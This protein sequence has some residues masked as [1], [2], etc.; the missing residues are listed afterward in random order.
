[1]GDRGGPSNGSDGNQLKRASRARVTAAVLALAA[2]VAAH[3]AGAS[4]A[5][6]KQ[7]THAHAQAPAPAP[8]PASAEAPI[9]EEEYQIAPGD[10]LRIAVWREPELTTEVSVRL[11]G[12]ITVP[13]LGDVIAS[14]KTP[15]QLAAEIQKSLSRFLEVPPQVTITVS[16]AISA[17]FFVLGEILHSGAFPLQTRTTVLQA[18]ALAGGFREFAKRERIVVV[19][20]KNGLRTALRVNFMEIEGGGDLDQNL[21]L[22]AGDTIL[23]P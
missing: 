5:K 14:G 20:E 21:V 4:P 7:D 11:D 19:R 6:D 13:L 17:R 9:V 10:V 22:E 23:V 2:A 15:N 3:P 1:M 16:Q 12:R 18:L 8:A